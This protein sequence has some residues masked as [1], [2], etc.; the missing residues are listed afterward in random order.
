MNT[1]FIGN[2]SVSQQAK[3]CEISQD[4]KEIYW[5]SLTRY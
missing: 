1:A 3:L 2:D 4:K 5:T